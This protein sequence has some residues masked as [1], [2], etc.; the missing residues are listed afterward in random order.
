M[1]ENKLEV[2]GEALATHQ[3]KSETKIQIWRDAL[4]AAANLSG[5]DLGTRYIF[6]TFNSIYS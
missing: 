6:K 5:W 1:Y 4:I 3:A 2:L